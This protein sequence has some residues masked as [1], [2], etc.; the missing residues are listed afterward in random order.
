[1]I[2]HWACGDHGTASKHF[3]FHSCYWGAVHVTC[4]SERRRRCPSQLPFKSKV[5]SILQG[6]FLSS[7]AE[8]DC[9]KTHKIHIVLCWNNGMAWKKTFSHCRENT[10]CCHPRLHQWI[11]SRNWCTVCESDL[12]RWVINSVEESSAETHVALL[13]TV[14]PLAG[15]PELFKKIC[16]AQCCS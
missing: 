13:L 9:T 16:T 3:G 4:W 10:P 11:F 5:R 2:K 15:G 8:P 14:T 12:M 1:M 6:F 7:C